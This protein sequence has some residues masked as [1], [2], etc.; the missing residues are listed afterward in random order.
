MSSCD[1]SNYFFNCYHDGL[2]SGSHRAKAYKNDLKD[3]VNFDLDS[4]MFFFF[5]NEGYMSSIKVTYDR[6]YKPTGLTWEYT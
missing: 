2:T 1:G 4:D 6:S 3:V 5:K